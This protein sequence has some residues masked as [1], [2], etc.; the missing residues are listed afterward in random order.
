MFNH[1]KVQIMTS[2]VSN[3]TLLPPAA[4]QYHRADFEFQR[5]IGDGAFGQVWRVRHKK[6]L[7]QFAIKQVQKTKILR[8]LDQFK[9][10]VAI[11]YTLDHPHIVKLYSHFED[12]KFVYMVM[13]LIEGGSLFHKLS[14]EN[15]LL[16]R[17]A[18]QY[19]REMVLAIE[20]LHTRDPAIIHRDIKPENILID[21]TGRLKLTDFGWANYVNKTAERMTSCGTLEYLPPEMVDERGHDTCADIWCLGIFLY[22]MLTGTTPFKA[23]GKEKTMKNILTGSFKFPLGFS[24]VAK[25]LIMGML[26]KD[27]VKRLDVFKVKAHRWLNVMQPIRETFIQNI[28][29][30]ILSFV[31]SE[32]TD[33]VT[34][35]SEND[36]DEEPKVTQETAFRKSIRDIKNKFNHSTK[37][38]LSNRSSL[39]ENC[40]EYFN[41]CQKVKDLE[42]RI[43]EKNRE[44]IRT[45]GNTKEMLSKIFDLNLDLERLEGQ[46]TNSLT[47]KNKEMHKRLGELKKII[48]LQQIYLDNLKSQIKASS[49]NQ[50]E[51]EKALKYLQKQLLELKDNNI[52][53]KHKQKSSI[54][55][56]KLSLDIIKTQIKE[57][58]KI[59]QNFN[60]S[61]RV[62]AKEISDFIRDKMSLSKDFSRELNR[63]IEEA[64]E[65]INEK[66][67]QISELTIE[68]EMKKSQKL[69]FLRK[70]KDEFSR[71]MR[72]LREEQ[73]MLHMKKT[74]ELRVDLKFRLNEARKVDFYVEP[75]QIDQNRKRLEVSR[76]QNLKNM[77][78]RLSKMK[79]KKGIEHK[80]NINTIENNRSN[81]QEIELF[82]GEIKSQYLYTDFLDDNSLYN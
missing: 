55:E 42:A 67:Q 41:M 76:M 3:K 24:H 32:K 23:N 27:T 35:Y 26:E 66:E 63:K 33:D 25:D 12:D 28:P 39:K 54:Y 13:D 15:I 1:N 56:M 52:E 58:D 37:E 77:L 2:Q 81:I 38:I 40:K 60:S 49:Q 45:V 29:P 78:I 4:E 14:R 17:V 82:I 51:E 64:E 74:E 61:D 19:F 47:E 44:I 22:E 7:K 34:A 11:M 70:K 50:A 16:E 80:E 57:K 53:S 59:I 65:T 8:I 68:Y 46:D 20:Y 21:K 79:T 18:A 75:T 73:R 30:K 31:E 5:K 9:R 62:L 43:S 36:T 72:K 71:Q 10:E 6:T 69:H 48:R